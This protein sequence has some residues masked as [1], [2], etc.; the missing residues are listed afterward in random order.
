MEPRRSEVSFKKSLG[1]SIGSQ[2]VRSS[3]W[4]ATKSTIVSTNTLN[5]FVWGS[6]NIRA[7]IS[8]T[9]LISVALHAHTQ[10]QV[11]IRR[12]WS[13]L[14]KT[15]PAAMTVCLLSQTLKLIVDDAALTEAYRAMREYF[16][17]SVDRLNQ[18]MHTRYSSM[19]RWIEDT[20]IRRPNWCVSY[21]LTLWRPLL[22]YGYS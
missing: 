19:L 5:T 7:K 17:L 3:V 15:D 18:L 20:S 12:R 1:R 22:P 11:E 21:T 16:H 9:F 4:T 8:D 10:T 13:S 6:W 14:K 2:C